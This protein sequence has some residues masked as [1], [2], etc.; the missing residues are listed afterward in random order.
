MKRVVAATL[1][2]A[3][4]CGG[5]VSSS[6]PTDYQKACADSA[7][8]GCEKS[9]ACSSPTGMAAPGDLATCIR[10]S[11]EHCARRALAKRPVAPAS[12]LR[13]CAAVDR[14]STCD[15]YGAQNGCSYQGTLKNGEP[16]L[17]TD[18]CASDFCDF[19]GV[20][21]AS[22]L[23]GRCAPAPKEGD[24]CTISC[25]P[26]LDL[27]CYP[28]STGAGHCRRMPGEGEACGNGPCRDGLDCYEDRCV[29]TTALPGEPCDPDAGVFCDIW[30]VNFCHPD[31]GTC[32]PPISVGPGEPCRQA[33]GTTAACSDGNCL[34]VSPTDRTGTCTPFLADGAPCAAPTSPRDAAQVPR[35]EYPA[36][37]AHALGETTG[38]CRIV[39]I[40]YCR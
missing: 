12:A 23:C 27:L 32:Q 4:A 30:R 16:C 34:Y 33:D 40:D 13:A 31:T 22:S 28:D 24:P 6:V 8:V 11:T 1:G 19:T 29:A 37:C 17:F 9:L 7:E 14:S 3:I 25:G 21:D 2:L 38:T 10:V 26:D 20:L 18:E 36:I 5:E 39:G 35:C 15:E